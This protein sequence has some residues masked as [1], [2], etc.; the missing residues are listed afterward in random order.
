MTDW[1]NW[2]DGLKSYGNL[3]DTFLKYAGSDREMDKS[4]FGEFMKA[5][6]VEDG[7][8]ESIEQKDDGKSI[9]LTELVG[10]MDSVDRRDKG[11][12]DGQF[13]RAEFDSFFKA[14][15]A[16]GKGSL[17]EQIN[18]D[19]SG[20]EALFVEKDEMKSF[21]MSFDK[22][23]DGKCAGDGKLNGSELS[24]LAEATGADI[25]VLASYAGKDGYLDADELDKAFSSVDSKDGGDD[26]GMLDADEVNTFFGVSKAGAGNG[27]GSGAFTFSSVD[28]DGNKSVN[29][30]EIFAKMSALSSPGDDKKWQGDEV[31]DLADKSGLSLDVLTK[32]AGTD[33]YLDETDIANAVK[34]QDS[35]GELDEAGFNQL[36]G[37]T[38]NDKGSGYTNTGL[39]FTD[40]NKDTSGI[41]SM[42][43]TTGEIFDHLI[44]TNTHGGDYIWEGDEEMKSLSDALKVDV[45][46]LKAAAGDDNKLDANDIGNL[47]A[48]IDGDKGD[49]NLNADQLKDLFKTP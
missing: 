48:R 40:V 5:I 39:N 18:T 15:N 6:G 4:E 22:G 45:S 32:M 20:K 28:A 7:S 14:D 10:R 30:G 13:D 31:K 34:A 37:L 46:L 42:F 38:G 27:T 41:E 33:G 1:A 9:S 29:S 26:D 2:T 49:G 35:D 47:V 12:T 16:N 17:F 23:S 19:P 8:F 36:F 43:A 24:A 3:T 25:S 44:S 11:D 21:V